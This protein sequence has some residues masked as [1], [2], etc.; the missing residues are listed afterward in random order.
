MRGLGDACRALRAPIVGGNVSLYNEGADGPIYPTPVVGLVGELPDA[1]RSG[2]LGFVTE[3]DAIALVTAGWAPSLAASELSKLRGEAVA[4]PLP[5]VDLGELKVLHAAIRQAVRSGALRSV[6]DVAEGGLLVAVA[7]SCLAGGVGASLDL[8]A[9]D[10]PMARLFGEGP[11]G[12]VAVSYTHLT[13]PT[14]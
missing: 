10:A 3:G 7:E 6:H 11:G 14:N 8:G 12:F 5:A 2:R 1:R 9:S 4:G 13:L